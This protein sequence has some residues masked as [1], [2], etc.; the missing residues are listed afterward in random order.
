M[1][2]QHVDCLVQGAGEEGACAGQVHETMERSSGDH[3]Q[4]SDQHLAPAAITQL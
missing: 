3:D 4:V 1:M 2:M